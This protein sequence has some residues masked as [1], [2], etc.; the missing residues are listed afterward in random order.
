M[1]AQFVSRVRQSAEEA[2]AS[3]LYGAESVVLALA[4]AQGI[5]SDL[6]PKAAS[7]VPDTPARPQKLPRASFS[8][9]MAERRTRHP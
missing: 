3:G 5:A 7:A 1:E 8:Q 9:P 2:F 6:L 4:N